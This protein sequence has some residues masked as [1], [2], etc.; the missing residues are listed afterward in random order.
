MLQEWTERIP[1]GFAPHAKCRPDD[2]AEKRLVINREL[3][4]LSHRQPY[5]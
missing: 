4:L 2:G 5:D 1:H 3:R